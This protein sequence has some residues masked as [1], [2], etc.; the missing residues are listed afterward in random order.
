MPW[1][2]ISSVSPAKPEIGKFT[3][4]I[5]PWTKAPSVSSPC[6]PASVSGVKAPSV[7]SLTVLAPSPSS[8]NGFKACNI[9]AKPPTALLA[10]PDPIAITGS[11]TDAPI[12]SGFDDKNSSGLNVLPVKNSSGLKLAIIDYPLAFAL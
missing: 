9:P 3:I 4:S 7:N 10:A 1:P 5:P 12:K 8:V 11:I 2:L 6:F